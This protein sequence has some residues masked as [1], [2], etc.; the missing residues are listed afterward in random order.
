MPEKWVQLELLKII[1]YASENWREKLWAPRALHDSVLT[2][3]IKD[4]CESSVCLV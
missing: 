2:F 3:N 4:K 1:W